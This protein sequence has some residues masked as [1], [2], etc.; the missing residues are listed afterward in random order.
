[1]YAAVDLGG[2]TMACGLASGDGLIASE[3]SISTRSNEGPQGV[4][5]RIR[6]IRAGTVVFPASSI[7]SP[8]VL[9]FCRISPLNGVM[10]L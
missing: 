10:F 9:D 1:M 3:K 6:P 4:V 5:G 7:P 2:T 8:G